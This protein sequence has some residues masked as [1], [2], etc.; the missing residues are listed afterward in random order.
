MRDWFRI[1]PWQLEVIPL[2][3]TLLVVLIWPVRGTQITIQAMQTIMEDAP[4]VG[5][6]EMWK[7]WYVWF[8][9]A[10]IGVWAIGLVRNHEWI[11]LERGKRFNYW[12]P[13]W[14]T[15][16]G[17]LGW[18]GC[19]W[20]FGEFWI[21][22]LLLSCILQAF[23]EKNR[24]PLLLENKQEEMPEIKLGR[25]FYYRELGRDFPFRPIAQH[26]IIMLFIILLGYW[27]FPSLWVPML[28]A[29]LLLILVLQFYHIVFVI[30]DKKI[31]AKSGFLWICIPIARIKE[32]SIF[33][34][35][36]PLNELEAM[37]C[38]MLLWAPKNGPNLRV[39]TLDG[40]SY[41]FGLNK[42]ETACKLITSVLN[43]MAK[44][45]DQH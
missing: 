27:I 15:I 21:P 11:L 33:D 10:T 35:H 2:I 17:L 13:I 24:Q 28:F 8:C 38:K 43:M 34:Y 9:F 36:P 22:V 7:R 26:I 4:W 41:L 29:T 44:T 12:T 20:Q 25:P 37:R 23:I 3:E 45:P 16:I 6:D 18:Y 30:T 39:D 19:Q 42:P 14:S 32:S 5:L 1:H 40:K 31:T